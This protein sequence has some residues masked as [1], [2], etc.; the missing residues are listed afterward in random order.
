MNIQIIM[1]ITWEIRNKFA[2]MFNTYVFK[3]I[4]NSIISSMQY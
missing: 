2:F 4:A 1:K 3:Y